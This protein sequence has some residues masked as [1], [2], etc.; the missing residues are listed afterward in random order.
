[1]RMKMATGQ[2][3]FGLALE[4]TPPASGGIIGYLYS[5]LSQPFDAN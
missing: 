2:E 3:L 4:S 1:M 5:Y